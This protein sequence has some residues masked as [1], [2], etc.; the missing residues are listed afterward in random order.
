MKELKKYTDFDL[1]EDKN[2]DVVL[3]EKKFWEIYN[4]FATSHKDIIKNTKLSHREIYRGISTNK[5]LIS[6]HPPK[7][8][9]SL[10]DE[11]WSNLLLSSFKSW[12]KFPK[13]I[14]SIIC[15]TDKNVA[16]NYGNV[17]V[18]IPLD[19]SK[20]GVCPKNDIWYSFN[21][22]FEN[23]NYQLSHFNS[24]LS[25]LFS[26]LLGN[27][28]KDDS[29]FKNFLANINSIQSLI[30]SDESII[31]KILENINL[32]KKISNF[33]NDK[34]I[35]EVKS[36]NFP[37]AEYL[38]AKMSPEQN[39]FKVLKYNNKFYDSLN[40][41]FSRELWSSDSCLFVLETYYL[42]TILPAIKDN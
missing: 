40:N 24:G 31:D 29:S 25:L 14:N 33:L 42:T 6:G 10:Q 12:S 41:N 4:N 30:K 36:G 21:H 2:S 5:L 18:L 37:L 39:M 35:A 8:R 7:N 13:R 9:Q 20:F 1:N 32:N 22:W 27:K 16:K 15:T 17:Y 34:F 38:E 26:S 19:G 11:N 23:E 28:V 3:D